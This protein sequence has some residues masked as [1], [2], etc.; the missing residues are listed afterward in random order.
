[1][2]L[3]FHQLHIFHAVAEY[4]SFS[5][6]AGA[7][8][9]TQPA[10][11]MQVQAL[12]E[13]FGTKLFIRST[14]RVNLSDAGKALLPYARRALELMK[15]TEEA[16]A[17][18]TQKLAGRLQFGASLTIGEHILP[19]I[20]GPFAHQYPQIT[21]SLK[22]M[23]TAQIVEDIVNHQLMFGLVE[24]PVQ[25]PNIHSDAVMN[26]ELLL[27]MPS[28]HP[29]RDVEQ[30]TFDELLAYPFVLREQGS[31]TRQ[32]MEDELR[33]QGYDPGKMNIVMELGST[34]A[35]KSAVEAGLGMSILSRSS[36]KHETELGTVLTKR[37]AGMTFVRDFHAVY[38]KSSLLPVTA[39]TFL[40]FL[41]HHD[42]GKWL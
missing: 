26:D 24:A 28:D 4:G 14:K 16:M 42:L 10:V 35:V 21:I 25:H 1:M 33:K 34:G 5:S 20:L 12:E 3:N 29:L 19:R 22:V 9:M 38:L 7:L 11:T 27:I 32:V 15:D 31:G 23:N 17:N 6:A 39:A 36:I 30:P 41:K 18:Y 40:S 8:G 2:A 37:I 13:Y